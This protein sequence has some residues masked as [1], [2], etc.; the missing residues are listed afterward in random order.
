MKDEKVLEISNVNIHTTTELYTRIVK[1]NNF[2]AN[3][4]FIAIFKRLYVKIISQ[5]RA[6]SWSYTHLNFSP[7]LFFIQGWKTR[8]T[9]GESM[10]N[11]Y[12]KCMNLFS[13]LV[14]TVP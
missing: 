8:G 9:E 11:S 10:Q 14:E 13:H 4:F 3:V 1:D 5:S 2:Y 6:C 12:P 7:V